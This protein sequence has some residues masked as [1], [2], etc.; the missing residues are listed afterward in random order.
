M[1]K[2]I[3][4]VL[5]GSL[6]LILAALVLSACGSSSSSSSSTTEEATTTEEGASSETPT[7]G[8][9]PETETTAS[10]GGTPTGKPIK[11][12]VISGL[13]GFNA[14][15]LGQVGNTAKV[16]E[17]AINGSGGINGSPVE[18]I[19]KD[20]QS[21]GSKGLVA[22]RELA[23][24][25]V[26]AV[27][28]A[29]DVTAEE[30]GPYLAEK[31]I[32][33]IGGSQNDIPFETGPDFFPSGGNNAG[34]LTGV[35]SN[36]K[37]AGYKKLGVLRCSEFPVCKTFGESTKVM[38]EQLG[39]IEVVADVGIT[40]SQPSYTAQCLQ[41]IQAGADSMYINDA[42]PAVPAAIDDCEQQGFEGPQ[43]NNINDTNGEFFEKPVAEGMVLSS[44]NPPASDTSTEGGKY[45][46][47]MLEKYGPKLKEEPNWNEAMATT[48]SGLQLFKKAAELGKVSGSS[49]AEEV[50]NGLYQ[51]KN[52]TIEGLAPPLTFTKGKGTFVNC[53]YA[54]KVE[55]QV[56]KLLSAEP[57]CLTEAQ[58][59]PIFE[60]LE[61]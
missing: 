14:I 37:N 17:E 61:E 53:W 60:A 5:A 51:I 3:K 27:A 50:F 33:I 24:E 18:V 30:Y 26:V 9:E 36:A 41:I 35:V 39:G 59:G 13:T 56:P 31:G 10:E 25:G 11:V 8:E 23:S 43:F 6:I 34:L 16:W 19:V 29:W 20:D 58:A 7:E 38:A 55:N 2:R 15:N 32:P 42:G 49:S 46:N 52:Y 54:S 44:P 12:G 48:W 4:P 28:G 57:E 1:L 22:A 21:E 40:S 45:F 47:E